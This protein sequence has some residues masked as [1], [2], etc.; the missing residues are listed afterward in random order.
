MSM[1]QLDVWYHLLLELYLNW[2]SVVVPLDVQ[3][4]VVVAVMTYPVLHCANV[5]VATGDCSNSIKDDG[6]AGVHD[7]DD[8]DDDDGSGVGSHFWHR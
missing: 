2:P 6:H 7:D 1:F 5:M 8:N 4:S 3:E